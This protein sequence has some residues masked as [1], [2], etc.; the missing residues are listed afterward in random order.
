VQIDWAVSCD[1]YELRDDGTADVYEAG[2]DTYY[3]ESV[4]AECE[5]RI[6][7]RLILEEGETGE[8]ELELLAPLTVPLGS[9]T[10]PIEADPGTNHRAGY[11]VNQIEALE[12][13]FP[14]ETEGIYV[15]EI[16]TNPGRGDSASEKW[17]RSVFLYVREGTPD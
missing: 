6:L 16:R 13:G 4:P 8:I 11:L 15:A 10:Y 7:V 17:R 5:L 1:S 3:V 14:A 2:F 9:K 12:V